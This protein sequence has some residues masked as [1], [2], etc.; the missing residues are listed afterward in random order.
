[1]RKSGTNRLEPVAR[2][3]ALG[4][5]TAGVPALSVNYENR[6]Q[7]FVES[8][9]DVLFYSSLYEIAK[10]WLL[11]EISLSFIAA[12]LEGNS[13]CSQV[14]DIVEKLVTGGNKTVF[15]IIDW[16][17]RNTETKSIYVLGKGERY[18]IENFLLDPVLLAALLLRE[19]AISETFFGEDFKV[20]YMNFKDLSEHGFQKIS[21]AIVSKIMPLS[22]ISDFVTFPYRNGFKVNAPRAFAQVQGHE[23]EEKIKH[24]FPY[25]KRYHKAPDLKMAIIRIVLDDYPDL[26]PASIIEILRRIQEHQ[27]T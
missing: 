21:D 24:E 20:S 5:L 12:G 4:I 26:I 6:R 7:V 13:N 14:Q 2:D 3:S 10:P 8:K 23:L 18:S 27:A 15:G 11:P 19:K 17:T 22:G 25:L 9:Y 1:M 16:D